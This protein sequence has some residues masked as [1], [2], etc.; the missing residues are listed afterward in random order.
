MS[1]GIPLHPRLSLKKASKLLLSL[2][3]TSTSLSK[4]C[5]KRALFGEEQLHLNAFTHLLSTDEIL[6]QA[7]ASDERIR[8]NQ[9]LSPLDGI[10]VTVKANIA[11]KGLPFTAGSRILGED[12]FLSSDKTLNESPFDAF[13]VQR[14]LR[15]SGAV[16]IGITNMDEF[17]MG[18]LGTNVPDKT[19]IPRNPLPFLKMENDGLLQDDIQ[20]LELPHL[21]SGGSSSGAASSVSFG[22]SLLSIGTDTG[23]SVRL[24]SA[25]NSVVGFKPTYGWMS[26]HGLIEYASSLDT[27]GLI[28]PSVDCAHLAMNCLLS[29]PDED[30]ENYQSA[31]ND[32]TA[33]PM[34]HL[35]PLDDV[36]N[37]KGTRIGIPS[38][39]C[40]SE[41]PSFINDAWE[42]S[43]SY[44]TEKYDA[45]IVL[46]DDE[47]LS[48]EW[49][50]Q[51]LAAYYVIACA[52]ASSNLSRYDGIRYGADH[53]SSF[54][55]D[56]TNK[57]SALEQRYGGH[58]STFFGDEVIRRI[59]CGN[60]VLSSDRYHSFYESA[61]KVRANLSKQ[62]TSIF[63]E[64]VDVMLVPTSISSPWDLDKDLNEI[65]ATKMYENDV[66][67]VPLSLACLPS[68]SVPIKSQGKE[69]NIVGFQIVGPKLGEE[70]VLKVAK[71]LETI[72][73]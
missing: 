4:Q 67:T 33:I 28:T 35:S 7:K 9:R 8:H 38:S 56:S 51:S 58:R 63:E 43:A 17:G 14:L 26:R 73:R 71:S 32:P 29:P 42:A 12:A 61:A 39:F 72:N 30:N 11:V 21:S 27:V 15:D 50:K 34:N 22:S 64:N 68:I 53:P 60:A 3:T 46:L 52:E 16:L 70:N 69:D 36:P 40:V 10:P 59:L 25:W 48:K 37:L 62:F 44:L 55:Y 47:A 23:G 20:Q 66:M 13:V 18:S 24:P 1:A 54:R 6:E 41:I 45:E 31:V 5:H 49:I 65:V 19:R 2:K 57:A